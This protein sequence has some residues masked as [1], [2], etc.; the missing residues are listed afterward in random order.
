MA[1]DI[2]KPSRA[3][4]AAVLPTIGPDT[5]IRTSS[6]WPGNTALSMSPWSSLDSQGKTS[7]TATALSTDRGFASDPG[8]GSDGGTTRFDPESSDFRVQLWVKP[9]PAASFPRGTRPVSSVSPNLIQKGRSTA[10]GGYW[11]VYLQMVVIDG[12]LRWAPMCVV[13]GADG[14]IVKA[15]TASRRVSL[16]EGEAYRITCTRTADALTM[17]VQSAD[18]LTRLRSTPITTPLAIDN[19]AAI[20][21]GHSPGTR[22]PADVYDGQLDA[23]IVTKG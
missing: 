4:D 10:V 15:N 5:T 2:H 14:T 17:T 8:Y 11:K 1:T 19:T 20:T 23:I 12:A 3:Q 21:V 13:K 22:D 7:P 16:I 9:T 18:G 6:R